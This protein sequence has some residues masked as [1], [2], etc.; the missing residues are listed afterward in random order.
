MEVLSGRILLRPSDLDASQ[1]FYR[2]VLQLA[3][4]RE[5]GHPGH[6]GIVFFMGAAM[7]EVSGAGPAQARAGLE[8]WMQVRDIAAEHARLSDSGVTITRPP[9]QEPWGL[10]E[11]WIED[12][13]GVA[14]VI[15]EIPED[16]PIRRDIRSL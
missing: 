9:K 3:V 14:I 11:M 15:V 6:P 12:P 13:D 7:L 2:D 1:H 10:V 16:H 4:A 5:F 8:L